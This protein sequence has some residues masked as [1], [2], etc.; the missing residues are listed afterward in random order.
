MHPY[1]QGFEPPQACSEW[2]RARSFALQVLDEG[3]TVDLKW[4]NS[5]LE[6]TG[7]DIRLRG[8]NLDGRIID[9][10]DAIVQRND[11]RLDSELIEAD[12]AG[13]GLLFLCAAWRSAHPRRRGARRFPDVRD[14]HAPKDR[15]RFTKIKGVLDYCAKTKSLPDT[16]RQTWS[17]WPDT[18]G[19][20]VSLL[21]TYL[22]AVEV[23]TEAGP[24]QL[25]DQHAVSTLIH[26]GWLEDPSVADFTLRRYHR[27]LELLN[28]WASL[29]ATRPEM[30]EMW[31]VDR[32]HARICEA[33]DGS[34]ATPRLF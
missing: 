33:R 24:A 26:E 19:V 2:C 5:H 8:R 6:R 10:G 14:A 3:V 4:W 34:H 9:D 30:V 18:P 7:H 27:Y 1:D 15:D 11:L 12:H 28:M 22:W 20:G 16:A 21:A 25:L 32:W 31:L 23:R 29:I 17:G 13:L